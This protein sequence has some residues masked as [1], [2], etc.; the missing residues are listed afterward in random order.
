[1]MVTDCKTVLQ[2]ALSAEMCQP[3]NFYPNP[4]ELLITF[5]FKF[6]EF[7]LI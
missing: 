3:R 7:Q 6:L 2:T 4:A 1:M 5:E